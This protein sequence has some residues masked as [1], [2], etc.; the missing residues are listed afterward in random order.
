MDAPLSTAGVV[1]GSSASTRR[2]VE[3][4][5]GDAPWTLPG[6]LSIPA[7]DRPVPGVVIVHGSGPN[8]R[9]GHLGPN[10]PYRDLA[11]G[12]VEAGIAVLRYDKR[13]FAHRAALTTTPPTLTVDDEVVDDAVAALSL[14]RTVPAVDPAAVFVLGHSLGGYLAPRIAARA[15]GGVRGVAILA[16]NTRGLPDVMLDQLETVAASGGAATPDAA[17][18]VEALRGQVA[19]LASPDLRP[20]TPAEELPFGVPA[21]YWLD[22]RAYDPVAT[23]ASLG[24]PILVVAGGRDYQVTRADFDGWQW[25]LAGAADVTFDWRPRLSHLL[26][27]GEGPASPADYAVAGHVAPEVIDVLA[28]WI[29][30]R[31]LPA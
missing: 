10:T 21:S 17:A 5:V 28:G 13:T 14:L 26:I 24:I 2:D 6:T 3:V 22:L 4:M 12:L 7:A 11:D 23:A 19:R 8:D 30:A 20:D 27:D 25:G 16:G 29:N 1:P 31:R 18:A 15:G 9:D